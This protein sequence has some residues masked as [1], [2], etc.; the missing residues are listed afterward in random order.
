MTGDSILDNPTQDTWYIVEVIDSNGCYVWENI[1]VYVDTCATGINN[2]LSN[3]FS[4]YPNPTN[5]VINVKSNLKIEQIKLY[6]VD[7]KLLQTT[8]KP[9]I[10]I[11]IKGIYFI[12]IETE[13]GIFV[14]RIVVN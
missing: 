8:V 6:S 10:L 11:E 1:L 2:G 3:Y 4:I 9:S 14:K 7:G 13:K 5:G 12:K